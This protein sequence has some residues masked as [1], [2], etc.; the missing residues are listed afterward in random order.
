MTCSRLS[1]GC[2]AAW[3]RRRFAPSFVP[4]SNGSAASSGLGGEIEE[5]IV[6][7]H[8]NKAHDGFLGHSYLGEWINLG[9]ST[10]TSDLRNEYTPVEVTLGEHRI[11][12]PD[13]PTQNRWVHRR[14]HPNEPWPLVNTER[15]GPWCD[16]ERADRTPGDVYDGLGEDKMARQQMTEMTATETPNDI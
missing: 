15:A 10:Q 13:R 1:S 2:H 7:G 16:T 9:A 5:S 4:N 14:P 12:H 6:H 8:S 11:P 3:P